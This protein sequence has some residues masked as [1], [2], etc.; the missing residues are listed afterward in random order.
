[1]PLI[2]IANVFIPHRACPLTARQGCRA[3]ISSQI[4][5]RRPSVGTA[6]LPCNRHIV[7]VNHR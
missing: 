2:T 1:M 3:Y 4:F 5:F 7:W 6:S